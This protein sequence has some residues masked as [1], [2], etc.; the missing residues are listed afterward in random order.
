M[1]DTSNPIK[2]IPP[3]SIDAEKSVIGSMIMSAD[4]ILAASEILLSR[5]FYARQYGM[6][7]QAI[8]EIYNA[9]KVADTV[10]ILEKLKEMQAPP[11]IRNAQFFVELVESVPTSANIRH[12]A[13]IVKDNAVKRE[14][15]KANEEIALSC[16]QG[17][18]STAD[19]LAE[20][21]KKIFDIV[22]NQGNI[23]GITPISQIVMDVLD[24][25][26][27]IQKS[28]SV[29][30]GLETGFVELDKKTAGLQK[31]DFILIA[32]RPSMGKTAFALNIA[33]YSA[34]KKKKVVMIFSLEMP[35]EQLVNRLVAMESYVEASKIRVADINE[36]EWKEVIAAASE[37]GRSKLIIDDTSS[38]SVAEMRT[39]CRRQTDAYLS[40]QYQVL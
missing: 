24:N 34:L 1:D 36:S 3:H 7:F 19:I 35:K 18:D 31:S 12:Y 11:E 15:I 16:Y 14:L 29:V 38:V 27:R 28:G 37:I 10:T 33:A 9:G 25:I 6:I 4:A 26:Q 21:E 39:K 22:Q 30:T 8:T 2:R 40:N 20:A 17:A 5:D 13:R 23:E 32:A